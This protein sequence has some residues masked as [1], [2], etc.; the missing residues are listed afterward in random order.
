VAIGLGAP[1]IAMA[2]LSVIGGR[3]VAAELAA[4]RA[5]RHRILV[6]QVLSSDGVTG[7][8]VACHATSIEIETASGARVHLPNRE[9]LEGRFDV[10]G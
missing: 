4:G 10:L 3:D 5:L 6:G 7:S 1:A 2:L 9:L 8:V